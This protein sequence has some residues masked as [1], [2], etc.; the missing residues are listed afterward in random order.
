MRPTSNNFTLFS[1]VAA[2]RPPFHV[3]CVCFSHPIITEEYLSGGSIILAF[4]FN[5]RKV[6]QQFLLLS[7]VCTHEIFNFTTGRW[8]PQ[9]STTSCHDDEDSQ[10]ANDNISL[11][12]DSQTANDNK[13]H[14]IVS[15]SQPPTTSLH[16]SDRQTAPILFPYCSQIGSRQRHHY[17]SQI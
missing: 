2:S 13:M 11:R 8:Q 3:F 14:Y 10:T 4:I 7:L 5:A 17:N 12:S 15:D 1:G 16:Y 9:Y 6:Q